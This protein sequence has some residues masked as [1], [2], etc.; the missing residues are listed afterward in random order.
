[1]PLSTVEVELQGLLKLKK[2][3]VD[4][5]KYG[6][7]LQQVCGS[8]LDSLMLEAS[9]SRFRL[10][11]DFLHAAERLLRMKLPSFRNSTSRSYYSMYHAA[12]AV[13]Y[14]YNFGDDHQAH[15][16]LHKG[17][18]DEFPECLRW[19]NDLKE[20]HLRRNEADYDPYPLSEAE[21]ADICRSQLRSAREFIAVTEAYL[22]SKGCPL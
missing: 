9:S 17:I 3:Q 19:R 22:R 13:S 4:L 6:I 7:R 8:S 1:M 2:G 12:R 21:F 18:P 15:K 10:A 16:E 5:L 20:A 11:Q 14:V